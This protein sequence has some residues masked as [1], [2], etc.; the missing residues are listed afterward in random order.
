M[1]FHT[2][3]LPVIELWHVIGVALSYIIKEQGAAQ[4][5]KTIQR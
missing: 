2:C 1:S 3:S 5:N 4:G